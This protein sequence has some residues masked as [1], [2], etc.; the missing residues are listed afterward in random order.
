MENRYQ[1]YPDDDLVALARTGN[2]LAIT[3]LVTRYLPLVRH[4]AAGYRLPGMESEDIVQEGLLGLMKAVSL[5]SPK[6]SSFATFVSL[7]I[8]TSMATAARTALSGKSF[9]L[10]DYLPLP[11]DDVASVKDN[12]QGSPEQH[13]VEREQVAELFRRIDTMLSTFEQ[14]AL[15]L[16]LSGHSYTDISAMLDTTSKAVDNALQRVRRKLRS[17]Q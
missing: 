15:K 16:Y 13:L 1:Q 11:T 4:K 9:P 7:C 17:A 6:R 5:Y 8:S 10:R 2:R 3:E 14:Q 12:H